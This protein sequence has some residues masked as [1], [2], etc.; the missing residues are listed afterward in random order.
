MVPIFFPFASFFDGMLSAGKLPVLGRFSLGYRMTV[1][2]GYAKSQCDTLFLPNA[3]HGVWSSAF[4]RRIASF[5]PNRLKAE[6][7]TRILRG[8]T[9]GQ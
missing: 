2:M 3:V 4:R 8:C 7:R 1:E 5:H 6:L 9:P